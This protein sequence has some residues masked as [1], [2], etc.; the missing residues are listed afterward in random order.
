M[1]QLF[2]EL[3]E[4]AKEFLKI[5]GF[6][7]ICDWFS[8]FSM[9]GVWIHCVALPA[10]IAIITSRLP[11]KKWNKITATQHQHKTF[12]NVKS[13]LLFGIAVGGLDC[14]IRQMTFTLTHCI[15]C[16]G[17]SDNSINQID[18]LSV[19]TER[20]FGF[21]TRGPSARPSEFISYVLANYGII[22]LFDDFFTFFVAALPINYR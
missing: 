19:F 4:N 9:L 14:F 3:L 15:L 21:C 17:K 8:L 22:N 7:I 10:F 13:S 6:F 20:K 2:G 11:N 12:P 1:S 16:V 18:N 5:S